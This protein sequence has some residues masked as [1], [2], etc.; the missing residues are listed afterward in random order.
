MRILLA[1]PD[2]DLLDCYQKILGSE[3]GETVTA[4]DGTHVLALLER[5]EFDI[6]IIDRDLPRVDHRNIIKG[7]GGKIPVIVLTGSPVSTHQLMDEVLANAYM[8][9]PF[10]PEELTGTVKRI[11]DM[12]GSDEQMMVGCCEIDI[13][14]FRITGGANVTV[15][16]IDVLQTLLSGGQVSAKDMACISAL[17]EKFARIGD[18]PRIRYISEKGFE[19]EAA[20]E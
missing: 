7:L 6:M 18:L 10:D 8:P 1:A 9:Y 13:A 20:H 2:R 15:Q 19:L 5:E 12:K 16:E 4:F 14:R 17:N 11:L 3:C